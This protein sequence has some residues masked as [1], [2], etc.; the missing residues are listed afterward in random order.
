M[1]R[2]PQ[3]LA[4]AKKGSDL[5]KQ[6]FATS[7]HQHEDIRSFVNQNLNE[8]RTDAFIYKEGVNKFGKDRMPS[9]PALHSYKKKH[10]IKGSDH[11]PAAFDYNQAL[12]SY[13]AYKQLVELAK[14][15]WDR[16]EL[17]VEREK[18]T[19]IPNQL[20]QRELLMYKDVLTK[21]IDIEIR[22]GV[23]QGTVSPTINFNNNSVNNTINVDKESLDANI[24]DVEQL[25]NLQ[26]RLSKYRASSTSSDRGS[27]VEGEVISQ[28]EPND[29]QREDTGSQK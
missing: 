12:M 6:G 14:V 8:G 18:A 1:S 29:I 10:W 22:I 19:K 24:E 7:I 21:I 17:Y 3:T 2:L 11:V 25:I 27:T 15:H 9:L 23:R 16:Y 4:N 26:L 20:I 13:D 5:R 28:S